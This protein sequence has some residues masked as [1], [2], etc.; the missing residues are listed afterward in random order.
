MRVSSCSV[1]DTPF[2][3]LHIQPYAKKGGIL[4]IMSNLSSS[5]LLVNAK[6]NYHK[7]KPKVGVE[8]ISETSPLVPAHSPTRRPPSDKF[9]ITYFIFYLLGVGHLLP[10]NFFIT[11][12]K[13]RRVT[14]PSS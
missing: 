9:F 12:G 7:M 8:R 5:S 1:N 2:L 6:E 4:K 10:W 3:Y 14:C 11:A 13:V